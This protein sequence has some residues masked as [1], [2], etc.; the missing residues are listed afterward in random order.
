MRRDASPHLFSRHHRGA[1]LTH[2]GQHILPVARRGRH[3]DELGELGVTAWEIVGLIL[4][5][6][7]LWCPKAGCARPAVVNLAE[8][9]AEPLRTALGSLRE[10][11]APDEK[12]ASE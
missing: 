4:R 1:K 11:G 3:R 12:A 2:A 10:L 6:C 9:P 7:E 8:F 5:R